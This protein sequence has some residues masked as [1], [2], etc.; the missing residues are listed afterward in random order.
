[1]ART[2]SKQ[3]GLSQQA[4]PDGKQMNMPPALHGTPAMSRVK[5]ARTRQVVFTTLYVLLPAV[6]A[7]IYFVAPLKAYI[8][9]VCAVTALPAVLAIDPRLANWRA[10]NGM[11]FTFV[12]TLAAT[13]MGVFLGVF[14]N[15]KE[16]DRLE[17]E[18]AVRFLSVASTDLHSVAEQ[19]GGF[20]MGMRVDSETDFSGS[21]L[22]HRIPRPLP[23]TF[24]ALLGNDTV[25]RRLS[26]R[27][28]AAL[29][30]CRKNLTSALR[31]INEERLPNTKLRPIVDA[32]GKELY[33]AQQI[34]AAE[35]EFMNGRIDEKTLDGM[36]QMFIYQEL[37]TTPKDVDDAI[38]HPSTEPFDWRNLGGGK[39]ST[40]PSV[41]VP[42]TK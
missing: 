21:D 25:L 2:H 34:L 33:H 31:I 42:S 15:T 38:K 13:T 12:L 6:A 41:P 24:F 40:K 36:N 11:L 26:P 23:E 1:M 3:H 17:V 10:S 27:T 7:F 5:L 30:S 18:R 28:L 22:A 19:M 8:A 32:Y 16:A 14:M 4:A 35:T 9:I 39:G 37:G 29:I 20:M